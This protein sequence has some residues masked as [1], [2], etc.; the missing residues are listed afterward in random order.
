MSAKSLQRIKHT[1][2]AAACFS[3]L[4]GV[5]MFFPTSLRA[6]DPAPDYLAAFEACPRD[7]VPDAG[8][9]DVP[10]DHP[11]AGDIDCIA[12]YGITKGTSPTTYSP[13]RPVIREHLALFLV[14]LAR[15]VGIR[16]PTA[17]DTPFKD[18]ADLPPSSREAISQIHQLEITTVGAAATFSPERIVSRAEIA[19]SLQRLMDLMAPVADGRRVF[20]YTPDDVND[21]DRRLQVASP[22]E[23]LEEVPHAVH[24]AVTQLYELGVATE[25][26]DLVYGPDENMS[27]ADMAGFMAAILDHS[28][29]RPKGMLMQVSPTRGTDDF[30]I[31]MMV[32]L[33]DDD[34]AP[35]GEVAVDWFYTAHPDGGLEDDGTCDQDRILGGGDC[36]WDDDNDQVTDLDGNLFGYLDA[37]PGATMSVYAWVGRRDGQAFDR[38]SVSFIKAQAKSEKGAD[39]LSV[40]HNVPA[41]AA[42]I[43]RNGAFLVDMDRRSSVEF[44]IQLL[45][46]GGTPLAREGTPIGIEVESR[47][48]RVEASDVSRGRPDP[49]LVRT[50]GKTIE[51]T[52][53]TTDQNGSATFDLRGPIREERLDIVTIES[54]CCADQIHQIA[55]SDGDPVLVTAR[56]DFELYQHRDGGR[57]AFTVK[58]DLYDQYGGILRGTDARYTG[59]PDTD[60]SATFGYRLYHASVPGDD[61]RYAIREAPDAGGTSTVTV[62]RRSV[63]AAI[64]IDIPSELRDGHEFLVKVDARIFSD[65]DNDRF[66]DSQEIRYVESDS[67]VWLVKE[68]RNREDYLRLVGRSLTGLPGLSVKEVE[69]YPEDGRY[70]TFFTLWS[71]DDDHQFQADGKS[72]GVKRFEELWEERVDTIG[73]LDILVY[74]PGFSLVVIK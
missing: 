31:A 55:W 5:S 4:I 45:D 58:Y 69:L 33:R 73:D 29:L 37:T 24:E 1:V 14:R 27:R 59:R 63:T 57:I 38:D 50:G 53:V 65:A 32:S 52:T 17:A 43:G 51:E 41:N 13:D 62:N 40:Q 10:A 44:T 9:A 20:G 19:V 8:F 11:D 6:A 28:N 72:V 22:F 35:T 61:G 34:F 18:I 54:T 16:V 25:L 46:Q 64:G 49:D 23:D 15:L 2:G 26:S 30:E 42:R 66:L 3:L 71:Y 67:T 74:L 39:S 60:L 7:I 47:E 36:V 70:R 56:P 68:A 12:Y 48:V 21:N